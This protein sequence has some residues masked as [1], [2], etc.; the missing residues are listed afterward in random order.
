MLHDATT[1]RGCSYLPRSLADRLYADEHLTGLDELLGLAS[2][3]DE[4]YAGQTLSAIRVAAGK[5]LDVFRA[6]NIISRSSN[7]KS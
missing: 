2:S 6:A 7:D 4:P 5:Y 1:V 3:W